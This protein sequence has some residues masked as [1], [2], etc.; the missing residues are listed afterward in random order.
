[1][2][3]IYIYLIASDMGHSFSSTNL[4][5]SFSKHRLND[6]SVRSFDKYHIRHRFEEK[7]KMD[8]NST[9]FGILSNRHWQYL[10]VCMPV[11]FAEWDEMNISYSHKISIKAFNFFRINMIS[12]IWVGALKYGM[13]KSF[14]PTGWHD[15]KFL[16]GC[17]LKPVQCGC[18]AIHLVLFLFYVI[19]L[20][21]RTLLTGAILYMQTIEC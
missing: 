19:N 8:K 7:E 12:T 16:V 20:E 10:F 14:H 3:W 15:F 2:V 17:P 5:F 6:R 13:F 1:M 4:F 21:T 11:H 18:L 9:E